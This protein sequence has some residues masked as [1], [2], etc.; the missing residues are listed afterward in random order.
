MIRAD[1]C[2][3]A[4]T[5]DISTG[6]KATNATLKHL[7]MR[8]KDATLVVV[9]VDVSANEV[10]T[11]CNPRGVNVEFPDCFVLGMVE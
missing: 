5:V 1:S 6:P 7:G 10:Q 2:G 11:Y 9:V 4:A 8:R 3:R